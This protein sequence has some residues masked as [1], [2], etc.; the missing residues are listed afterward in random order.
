MPSPFSRE[1][2]PEDIPEP[3]EV[4][5]PDHPDYEYDWDYV[6]STDPVH[7]VD[8]NY[9]HPLDEV[10]PAWL[11]SHLSPEEFE[12]SGEGVGFDASEANMVWR[13]SLGEVNAESADWVKDISGWTSEAA[14]FDQNQTPGDSLYAE[15]AERQIKVCAEDDR[16][17]SERIDMVIQYFWRVVNEA[18]TSDQVLQTMTSIL[19]DDL[20]DAFQG[21]Q[22]SDVH[23]VAGMPQTSLLTPP[24]TPPWLSTDGSYDSDA[25]TSTPPNRSVGSAPLLTTKDDVQSLFA[26]SQSAAVSASKSTSSYYDR[27]RQEVTSIKNVDRARYNKELLYLSRCEIKDIEGPNGRFVVDPQLPRDGDAKTGWS[28]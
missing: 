24:P 3:V 20:D 16:L 14:G 12:Q 13:N 19:G 17:L 21:L 22:I 27:W 25:S 10:D 15:A 8:T 2:L 6:A 5:G 26:A 7:P 28:K 23:G 11:L 18:N 9:A 4:I 1:V